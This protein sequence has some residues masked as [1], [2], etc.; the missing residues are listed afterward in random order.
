MYSGGVD[1][2]SIVAGT[3][4]DTQFVSTMVN[5][6]EGAAGVW[7]DS[8]PLEVLQSYQLFCEAFQQHYVYPHMMGTRSAEETQTANC[9]MGPTE[10]V[11]TL[12]QDRAHMCHRMGKNEQD[13]LYAFVRELKPELQDRLLLG[14]PKSMESALELAR[15]AETRLGAS[16]GLTQGPPTPL[17]AMMNQN[18]KM[19]ALQDAVEELKADKKAKEQ[20]ANVICDFC[21]R[22]GHSQVDCCTYKSYKCGKEGHRS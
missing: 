22:V 16:T 2:K 19:N 11:E 10:T 14:N 5:M 12:Y 1:P 15:M 18:P 3:S 9:V 13:L 8:L 17:T 4:A 6:L 7:L 20:A 21:K